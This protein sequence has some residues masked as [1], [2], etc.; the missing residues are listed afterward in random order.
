MRSR[1]RRGAWLVAAALGLLV[2]AEP[3]R[4]QDVSRSLAGLRS[5]VPAE[6]QRAEAAILRLGNEALAAVAQETEAESADGF[7]RFR[8]EKLFQDLLAGFLTEL[9]KEHQ[10][11][12]LDRN[13]LTVFQ[14]RQAL[15][16]ERKE[17]QAKL[18]KAKE[19]DPNIGAIFDDLVALERLEEREALAER[20]AGPPL[21]AAA[22]SDLAKL[23]ANKAAAVA[24]NP[25]I[26][27][28]YAQF[29]RLA[30]RDAF[31]P[32][33]LELNDL[34]SNRAKELEERIAERAPRVEALE[35]RV[36][37]MGLPGLNA[38]LARAMDTRVATA[39]YLEELV[40]R[41]LAGLKDPAVP[42]DAAFD[43]T[44]YARG[45][46]WAR[47]ADAG[48]G[49]AERARAV[50]EKHLDL[51][52]RDLASPEYLIR[53]R[54]A[55]EL[56]RLGDRGRKA[57]ESQADKYSF[58]V[59]LLRWRVRP[60]TYARTGIDFEDYARLSFREK[61]RKVFDYA[62]VAQADAIPTL[63]A[64]VKDDA[65][66]SSIFV[67]IAAA[68][69]LI[70]LH[71]RYGY[72]VLTKTHPDLALKRPEVSK[73]LLIIQGYEH[74][75]D[76]NYVEAVE[77]FQKIL[78]EFPF[79]FRANYHIAF[80]YLLLKNFP[81]AIHH[82]EIARRISPQDQLTLYNLAC[83]YA[84]AGGKP[85]E[86]LEALEASVKAGFDDYEHLEKDPDLESLRGLERYRRL[87]QQMMGQSSEK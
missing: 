80:A 71:D 47:E 18:A 40:Q 87:V 59:G 6:Q 36:A 9:E 52:V 73:E 21:D 16:V 28:L 42:P 58:L 32:E 51:S 19:A 50:L 11:L 69:A 25:G 12:V 55:E 48:G 68:T 86:A 82:F 57:L 83:A 31:G 49:S 27:E 23:R 17:Y 79:D 39:S 61:R 7:Y 74:I 34:E 65:L 53:E 46:L 54:A 76:K 22:S 77:S 60:A 45:L 38:I 84:L 37:S 66:E 67:K 4:A 30:R 81:K 70:G 56:Y 78:D 2:G 14:T 75:R 63:R 85:D 24:R 5:Q 13:E 35:Q 72:D 64:V 20:K 33:N 41:T 62:R 15:A 3:C 1:D 8:A 29:S 44:R 43:R 10:S 26:E